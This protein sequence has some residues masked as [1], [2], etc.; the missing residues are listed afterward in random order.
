MSSPPNLIPVKFHRP[1]YCPSQASSSSSSSSSP[2]GIPHSGLGERSLKRLLDE[3]SRSIVLGESTRLGTRSSL[4]TRLD[5]GIATGDIPGDSGSVHVEKPMGS[6]TRG[7]MEK[8][9][10]RKSQAMM[11]PSLP[12]ESRS[13]SPQ[14][15]TS[16][17][18]KRNGINW[19]LILSGC[20]PTALLQG[21]GWKGEGNH[22]SEVEWVSE[23]LKRER[24]GQRLELEREAR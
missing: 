5:E 19:S 10:K 20:T 23:D 2:H 14:S 22:R 13:V 15:T 11:S 16:T 18:A 24:E 21:K 6:N 9:K 3:R 1:L 7:S 8:S 4:T 12:I 17:K